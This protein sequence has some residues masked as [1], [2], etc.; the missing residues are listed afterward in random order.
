[1]PEMNGGELGIQF[2]D[3]NVKCRVL[4]FTGAH[5]YPDLM[6]RATEAGHKFELLLNP[7]HPNDFIAALN[8]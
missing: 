6:N 5:P 8:R 2:R 3:L 7:V 4:L 1:M